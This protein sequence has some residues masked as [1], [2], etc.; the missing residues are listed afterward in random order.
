M[1]YYFV[2]IFQQ[3]NLSEESGYIKSTLITQNYELNNL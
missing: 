3:M 2:L 1:K